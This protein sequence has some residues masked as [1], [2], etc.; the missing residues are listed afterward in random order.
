MREVLRN[1]HDI[2]MK[3]AQG[4][5]KRKERAFFGTTTTAIMR[6]APLSRVDC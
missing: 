5:R 1:G 4:D 3:T 6:K 2:V